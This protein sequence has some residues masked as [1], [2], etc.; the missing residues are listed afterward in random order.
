[1][2][3]VVAAAVLDGAWWS[4]LVLVGLA[5]PRPIN[6]DTTADLHEVGRVGEVTVVEEE[7]DVLRVTVYKG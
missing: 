2:V 7:L 6:D 1:M 5:V 4:C 3:V